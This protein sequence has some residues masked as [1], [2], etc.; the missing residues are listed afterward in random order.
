MPKNLQED[1]QWAI[2]VI[3]SNK[4]YAGGFGG[5]KLSEERPEVKAWTD[6][7][8]LK[9]IPC[10]KKEIERLKHYEH[11]EGSKDKKGQ[12]KPIH[13]KPSLPRSDP[14]EKPKDKLDKGDSTK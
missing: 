14:K 13:K 2:D 9:N 3:S 6:L 12:K 4:L 7:I 8:S 11:I 1:I 5:F 10:S